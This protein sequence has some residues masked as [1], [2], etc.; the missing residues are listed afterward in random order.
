MCQPARALSMS[1]RHPLQLS[2]QPH[3]TH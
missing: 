1:A 2:A 3:Q